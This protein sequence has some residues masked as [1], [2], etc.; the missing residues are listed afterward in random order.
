M[1]GISG[2]DL[3]PQELAEVIGEFVNSHS[4]S[5]SD[6]EQFAEAMMRQHRT[7]QQLVMSLFMAVVRRWA[8]AQKS[9]WFDLRNEATVRTSVAIVRLFEENPGLGVFPFI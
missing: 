6:R 5:S 8:E 1:K 3:E 9:G 7:L 2:G 4:W